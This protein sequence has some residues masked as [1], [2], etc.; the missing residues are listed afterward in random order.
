M[1]ASLQT[2]RSPLVSGRHAAHRVQAIH[3]P[4][5]AKQDLLVERVREGTFQSRLIHGMFQQVLQ[6]VELAL[7]V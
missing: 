6:S 2:L 4:F 7:Q 1:G 3:R 5:A